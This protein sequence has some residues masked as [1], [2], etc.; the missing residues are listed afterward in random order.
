MKD[1]ARLSPGA[2]QRKTG[3][4]A[5]EISEFWSQINFCEDSG[6][7][8]WDVLERLQREATEALDQ[9]PPDLK[10]ADAAT[11]EAMLRIAGIEMF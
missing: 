8:T 1:G 3:D 7:T 6:A 2:N 5:S 9:Q 11:A 4:R 10:R